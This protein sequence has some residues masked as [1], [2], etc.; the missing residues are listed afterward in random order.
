[1]SVLTEVVADGKAEILSTVNS[2]KSVT[3]CVSD[4]VCWCW[5]EWPDI[6]LGGTSFTTFFPIPPKQEDLVGPIL[7]QHHSWRVCTAGSHQQRGEDRR[8][9]QIQGGRLKTPGTTVDLELFPVALQGWHQLVEIY[10]HPV[11]LA[12]SC[13]QG[14]LQSIWGYL[15]GFHRS[16][17]YTKAFD[18]VPYQSNE[19]CSSG[20]PFPES[21]LF[22]CQD[23][24]LIEMPHDVAMNNMFQY[25]TCYRG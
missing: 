6:F 12:A 20:S 24:K 17:A 7:H 1:M 9:W 3:R 19:L 14:M 11:T 2:F 25:L 22:I 8:L 23:L 5:Y 18:E 21:M 10:S 4:V 16:W 13:A 15:H